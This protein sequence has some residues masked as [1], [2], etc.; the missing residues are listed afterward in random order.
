[1][2]LSALFRVAVALLYGLGLSLASQAEENPASVPA[3]TPQTPHI[4]LLLPL[5][6][7]ALGPSADAIKSGFM[8]GFERASSNALPYVVYPMA[9][10]GAE[11]V[12]TYQ[13]AVRSGARVV[14]GP[15]TIPALKTLVD[16]QAISVPTLGLNTLSSEQPA[17]EKLYLLNLSGAAEAR[18]VARK[19]WQAGLKR[20]TTLALD[21]AV[22]QR[23]QQAFVAEWEKLGG[24]MVSQVNVPTVKPN[25]PSLKPMLAQCQCD[26]FFLAT[27]ATR[28]RTIRPYLP[29]DVAVYATSQ[30]YTGQIKSPANFDLRNLR[31]YDMPWLL[32][33]DHPAVMIYSRS[34][35]PLS[36]SNERLYALGIDAWRL[37]EKMLTHQSQQPLELDGVSGRLV[38]LPDGQFQRELTGAEIQNDEVRLQP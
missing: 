32:Q 13:L 8:A 17:P 19:A 24:T 36:L 25:Y 11:V 27:D 34:P 23:M 1:M 33:L 4:A 7:K 29:P 38:L 28:A 30:A 37:A 15:L 21:S 14:V 20:A 18:L 35:V 22:D 10:E 5:Q 6:S 2:R 3:A 9:D 31:F 26:V 12:D 16:R